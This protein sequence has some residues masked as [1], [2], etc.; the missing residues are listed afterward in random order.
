MHT[1]Q[2]TRLFVAGGIACAAALSLIAPTPA[3]AR[4]APAPGSPSA[5]VLPPVGPTVPIPIPIALGTRQYVS[6]TSEEDNYFYKTARATCPT[7]TVVVGTGVSFINNDDQVYVDAIIPSE[8]TVSVSAYADETGH[9]GDWSITAMATCAARPRNYTIVHEQDA[10][11]SIEDRSYSAYCP[12]GSQPLAPGF[13]I[14]RSYGQVSVTGVRAFL[15]TANKVTVSASEDDTGQSG[16]WRTEAYA[17]CASNVAGL[18]IATEADW[19]ARTYEVDHAYCPAGKEALGAGFDTNHNGDVLISHFFGY[20]E[21]DYSY[22]IAR[23][24]EDG[25]PATWTLIVDA[26]CVT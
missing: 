15:G 1:T 10:L 19:A 18:E 13:R 3:S 21:P 25:A 23:E 20:P 9:P 2:P 17:V 12:S 22:V 24:D 6:D 14:F 11:A 8:T 16:D 7:G 4:L 26:I 5:E